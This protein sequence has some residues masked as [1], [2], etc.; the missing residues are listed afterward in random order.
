MG[1]CQDIY[2]LVEMA[3]DL[4]ALKKDLLTFIDGIGKPVDKPVL[5]SI[6][7]SGIPPA[8]E[9]IATELKRVLR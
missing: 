4:A 2:H 8:F 7:Y 6:A 5:K 9:W 3:G 1:G